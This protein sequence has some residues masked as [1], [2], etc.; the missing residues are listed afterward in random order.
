[1]FRPEQRKTVE[2]RLSLPEILEDL[3]V[4]GRLSAGHLRR[5]KPLSPGAIHPLVFL[6][7]QK[8]ADLANPDQTLDM[9]ALLH[10][11]S[12]RSE[13]DVVEIDPLKINV[14]AVAEVMSR[15]FAERHREKSRP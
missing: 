12:Q 11:L 10:W 2:H 3:L 7:E 8:I 15:A 4:D 9:S 6:A 13:Q 1:M 14:A 5:L